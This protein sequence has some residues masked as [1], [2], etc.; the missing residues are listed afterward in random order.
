[1]CGNGPNP[2]IRV[3]Q[4][5]GHQP[6][7]L[8]TWASRESENRTS[9]NVRLR[10]AH[11]GGHAGK[12][13]ADL[14]SRAF[15]VARKVRERTA[16]GESPVSVSSAAV[17]L[18]QKI[19]G[20]LQGRSVLLLGAGEMGELAARHLLGK[21]A[22]VV[23]V[24]NRTFARAQE[25]ASR[26]GG[27]AVDYRNLPGEMAQADIV[28]ASTGAPHVVVDKA[29]VAAALEMR[30]DR[31]MFLIDIA[32]PRDVEPGVNELENVYLYDIDDLQAVVA[33]NLKGREQEAEEARSIVEEE[34]QAFIRRREAEVLSRLLASIRVQAESQRRGE[35]DKTLARLPALEERDRQALD[36][37]TRA[38][39]NKLFHRPFAVLREMAGQG[40]DEEHL[41][42]LQRLFG[43]EPGP[44]EEPPPSPGPDP[45]E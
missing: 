21:G 11:E 27:R 25:L 12:A 10:I 33:S 18:A 17:D 1:M 13:L 32:V 45:V 20:S 42:F 29:M 16:I 39:V 19:F 3:L 40:V 41:E 14:F 4:G 28:I 9:S 26:L 24:A 23:L 2:F 44:E 5:P 6:D 38:I 35:L 37:M 7:R 22:G 36:A 30:R 8:R 43:V 15:R 31:P 34:L